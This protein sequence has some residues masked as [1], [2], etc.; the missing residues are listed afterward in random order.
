MSKL[1]LLAKQRA[2]NKRSQ[3][4][5]LNNDES[6][7]ESKK[8]SLSSLDLL[9]K[10]QDKNDSLSPSTDDTKPI[11]KLASRAAASKLA[12]L[13]SDTRL[14]PRPAQTR[15]G[16]TKRS[17]SPVKN[18]PPPVS[19][20]DMFPDIDFSSPY[21]S[22]E[23][24]E[25][26]QSDVTNVICETA[27]SKSRQ[28]AGSASLNNY[29]YNPSNQAVIHA[30]SKPSPDDIVLKAQSQAKKFDGEAANGIA[31]MKISEPSSEGNFSTA[32]NS[33]NYLIL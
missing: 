20:A 23:N 25:M 14:P 33:L 28:I 10:L 13:S 4:T 8:T 12:S 2:A 21:D 24:A 15:T 16:T 3:S 9:D 30:F 18:T 19:A 7:P 32:K 17:T 11:S 29:I 31:K 26:S 22:F 1:A 5:A 6:L 27:S